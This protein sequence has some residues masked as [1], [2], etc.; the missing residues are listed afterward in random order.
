MKTLLTFWM[1]FFVSVYAFRPDASANENEMKSNRGEG[2]GVER[3]DGTGSQCLF[4]KWKKKILEGG[5]KEVKSGLESIEN[6]PPSCL[7]KILDTLGKTTMGPQEYDTV[8]K[9]LQRA[10]V[11][12]PVYSGWFRVPTLK[13]GE[14][15]VH[16][17]VDVLEKLVGY[18]EPRGEELKRAYRDA[19]FLCALIRA[20]GEM[21]TTDAAEPL[22]RFTFRRAG[23]AFR[24]EVSRAIEKMR[25]YA[26][27]GLLKFA[28][29][30]VGDWKRDRDRY[31]MQAYAE[32]MLT[33]LREGDP[34]SALSW[35]DY[36]LKQE[37]LRVYGKHRYAEAVEAI[38]GYTDAEDP[39]IRV[40]ARDSLKQYFKGPRPRTVS[41]HL[42]LTGGRETKHR[43]IVYMNFRQRAVH[44]VRVELDRLTAGKYKKQMPEKG[45]VQTLF[46][47]QDKRRRERD[48]RWFAKA[49]G[50]WESGEEKS[51]I[52]FMKDL[53]ARE[54]TTSLA[55][56]IAGYFHRHAASLFVKGK[57]K[58]SLDFLYMAYFLHN[59]EEASR[60]LLS[61]SAYVRGL[62]H[63]ARKELIPEALAAHEEA[64]RLW[65]DNLPAARAKTVL[66]GNSIEPGHAYLLA[67]VAGAVSLMLLWMFGF[68]RKRGV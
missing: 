3:K 12:M 9:V 5:A 29:M 67:I 20:L 15:P 30:K 2:S 65:S 16:R 28:T 42:K 7:K 45:L 35:A 36:S 24:H 19:L 49:I 10:G 26:V 60:K 39:E 64:I 66:S 4:E 50:K 41:R 6:A 54:P 8:R 58:E 17:S 56:Q 57:L 27:P 37:L 11:P 61:E 31:L 68:L 43:Q 38:V 22:I 44:E 32:Y 13:K 34:A 59:D 21:E 48:S 40:A 18:Q 25:S 55:P 47:E 23:F 53:L 51:A 33:V 1:I 14:A 52:E 62:Y 46:E 63:E